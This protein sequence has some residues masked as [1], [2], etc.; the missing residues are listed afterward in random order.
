LLAGARGFY[1]SLLKRVFHVKIFSDLDMGDAYGAARLAPTEGAAMVGEAV[2]LAPA[3]AAPSMAGGAPAARAKLEVKGS[4]MLPVL[5]AL[6]L[7]ICYSYSVDLHGRDFLFATTDL[8]ICILEILFIFLQL[9][10]RF[11]SE[12]ILFC[13]NCSFDLHF[14]NTFC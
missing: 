13:Y 8:W 11:A 4:T 2:L 1:L 6:H 10:S 9:F 5:P 7:G 12:E 14:W 3:G